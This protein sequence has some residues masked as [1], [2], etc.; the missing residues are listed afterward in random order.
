MHTIKTRRNNNVPFFGTLS[1]KISEILLNIQI[2]Y[3]IFRFSSNF[4][5]QNKFKIALS[6]HYR[7]HSK[8]D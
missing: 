3:L 2:R 7:V 5:V 6:V 8:V 1:S 4:H